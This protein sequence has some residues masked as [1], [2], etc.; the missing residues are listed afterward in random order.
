MASDRNA[1]ATILTILDL[2]LGLDMRFVILLAGL[3]LVCEQGTAMVSYSHSSCS[4]VQGHKGDFS[5]FGFLKD[6]SPLRAGYCHGSIF[7]IQL[8]D[9]AGSQR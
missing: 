9:C 3:D 4:I 2:V 7:A 8:S 5:F 1:R 6:Q